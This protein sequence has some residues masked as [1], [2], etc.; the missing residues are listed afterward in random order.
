MGCVTLRVTGI[1]HGHTTYFEVYNLYVHTREQGAWWQDEGAYSELR[2]PGKLRKIIHISTRYSSTGIHIICESTAT[3]VLV[4][5][6]YILV[7]PG[8]I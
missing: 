6:H 7:L 3:Y 1:S 8:A 4:R 5:V 2:P